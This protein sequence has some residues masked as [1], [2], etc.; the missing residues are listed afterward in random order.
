MNIIER[1]KNVNSQ[2]VW[3]LMDQLS[4][5]DDIFSVRPYQ[6]TPLLED[7]T[8]VYIHDMNMVIV[9]IDR[10]IQ[11][12]SVLADEELFNNESPLYFT[13]REHW[14]SPIYKLQLANHG[15]RQV[16]RKLGMKEPSI[17]G[18]CLTNVSIINK[19]DMLEI[20]NWLDVT[21]IDEVHVKKD[22]K[23]SENYDTF[24]GSLFKSYMSHRYFASWKLDAKYDHVVEN[25]PITQMKE[26]EVYEQE[27]ININV[28]DAGNLKGVQIIKPVRNP[29]QSIERLI[30]LENIKRRLSELKIFTQYNNLL[31]S[32]GAKPHHI[33]LHSVFYGNPGTGKSTVGRLFASLLLEAGMLS[34]GHVVFVNGRQ[35]FVGRLFGD[36]ESAVESIISL[37]E[38]GVLFIDEAYTLNGNHSDDPGKLVL[39]MLMQV[40]ADERRRDL[41]I[42][43]AGY[44]KPLQNL[45]ALNPGL[46]SRFAQTNRYHFP[47]YIPQE[48]FQ[49]AM[50]RI[51]EYGYTITEEAK[52]KLMTMITDDYKHRDPDT[53]GNGRYVMNCMEDIFF[54]H[55]NRCMKEN[56]DNL[57]GL[58]N[59]ELSDI[60]PVQQKKESLMIK[61]KREIGFR[62]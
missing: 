33:S 4:M 5:E 31:C 37:A 22:L 16:L 47:D 29:S 10:H 17:Y 54:H 45:L 6:L 34:K 62:T 61:T 3:D 41:A 19:A 1:F 44:E 32:L 52:E 9:Y 51:N 23:V 59:I 14:I 46:D 48:L 12:Q 39:P 20:W 28:P 58:H 15:I 11:G 50:E 25:A 2:T 26:L 49:I 55:G 53:F 60:L 24:G 21:M 43:I 8:Y 38:G 18:V 35:A 36:E 7:D 30:G 40:M 42:I 27:E 56:I 57:E 13:E